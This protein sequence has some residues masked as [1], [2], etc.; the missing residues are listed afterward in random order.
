M[1]AAG[2]ECDVRPIPATAPAGG[3]GSGLRMF[4]ED[5]ADGTVQ[6]DDGLPVPRH[7]ITPLWVTIAED[8]SRLLGGRRR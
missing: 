2:D 1:M 3:I 8:I 4:R 5:E 6:P 7:A